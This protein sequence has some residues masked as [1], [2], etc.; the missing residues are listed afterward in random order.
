MVK[1]YYNILGVDKNV[2]DKSLKKVYRKLS[3]KYHPDVNKDN[4]ESEEKFK[5]IAEAYDVLS[6]PQKR[7]NYDTYG[8]P[9][10]KQGN[11]FG[12]GFDMN[13]IFEQF[14][15][16]NRGRNRIKRG[17]DIRVNIKLSL[18]EVFSG[19]HKKIKYK[20]NS[21]CGS[22]SG[23]G[24]E[25]KTCTTCRGLGQVN[26]IQTTPFGRMQSTVPCG[27]CKGEGNIITKPCDKCSG[28]GL[29]RVEEFLD[30][31]IPPGI[32]EGEQL[33]M[34]EK[35]NS[36]KGGINGELIINVIELPHDIFTRKNT[37][38]HQRLSLS[39]KELVLGTSKEIK[40]I[41]G[42][43][44]LNIKEGTEIG[45]I[46][47]VPQKGLKR[48]NNRGDLMLEVWLDIPKNI[49]EEEKNKISSL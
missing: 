45:N 3:K 41:D 10:G 38:L 39:Y 4:P 29:K 12:G 48:L 14:F 19:V 35:G 34:K 30:F 20:R 44:R 25:N 22:C 2:D 36:I 26:K 13:D 16:N 1:D 9:D 21:S 27:M 8:S 6:D 46:L 31:D 28:E 42:K 17:S 23:T 37:D 24:G 15:G 32:M 11:P 33:V 49:S 5:E 7:Q 47:R 40:T 43:I 18:E